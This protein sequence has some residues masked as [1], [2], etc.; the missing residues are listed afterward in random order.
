LSAR[1]GS[2]QIKAS[3]VVVDVESR[4]PL[5][6]LLVIV[7][8]STLLNVHTKLVKSALDGKLKSRLVKGSRRAR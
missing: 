7:S 3:P 8:Q 6:E 1:L 2:N 5:Q 4:A